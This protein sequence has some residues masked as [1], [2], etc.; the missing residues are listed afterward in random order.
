M[1]RQGLFR[2]LGG[3]LPLLAACASPPQVSGA[4]PGETDPVAD[5]SVPGPPSREPGAALL[6]IDPGQAF[7]GLRPSADGWSALWQ[8]TSGQGSRR[9]VERTVSSAG[10]GQPQ[11]IADLDAP[12]EH[13]VPAAPARGTR[14]PYAVCVHGAEVREHGNSETPEPRTWTVA[15]HHDTAVATRLAYRPSPIPLGVVAWTAVTGEQ[16]EHVCHGEGEEQVC[17]WETEGGST[18]LLATVLDPGGAATHPLTAWEPRGRLGALDVAMAES[19]TASVIWVESKEGKPAVLHAAG[20]G[21]L[22]LEAR[23]R[24]DVPAPFAS[25]LGVVRSV[26]GAAWTPMHAPARDDGPGRVGMF[27][28]EADGRVAKPRTF[29][30]S[31]VWPYSGKAFECAGLLWFVYVGF[32]PTRHLELRAVRL[33]ET[34]A[35]TLPPLWTGEA[36]VPEGVAGLNTDL[37]LSAACAGDRAAVA[38]EMYTR[39]GKSLLFADWVAD[40]D[41]E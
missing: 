41:A 8:Y 31:L 35:E 29:V 36:A 34:G 39:E 14:A 18:R 26:T 2:T 25:H 4:Q 32:S 12:C 10:H 22:G 24:Q 33:T 16:I 13:G 19:G 3:A 15:E 5:R 17:R 9:L 28:F 27:G 1:W 6:A 23:M 30:A 21:P 11:P 38:G 7:V 20:V 40:S 37:E